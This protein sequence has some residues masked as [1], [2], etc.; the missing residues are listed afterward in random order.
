M[1]EKRSLTPP[2][3]GETARRK[4]RAIED[5]RNVHEPVWRDDYGGRDTT[6]R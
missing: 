5:A 6:G 2:L 1:S 4:A 3:T